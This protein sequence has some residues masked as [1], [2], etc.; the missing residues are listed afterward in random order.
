MSMYDKFKTDENREVNGIILDYGDFRVRVA[1]AGGQN[2]RYAKVLEAK[3]RPYQRAIQTETI[4]FELQLSILREVYA[5][6]V[7]LKWETLVGGDW[8]EGIEGEDGKLLPVTVPN[9]VATFEALPDLFSDIRAQA[10][11]QA[12]FRADL[13]KDQAKN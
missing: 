6:S 8:K 1:R 2:K 11:R 4:N 10:D 9:L 7:I 12:L 5:E 3:S 13:L